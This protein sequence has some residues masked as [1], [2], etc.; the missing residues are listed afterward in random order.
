MRVTRFA[1]AVL[2]FAATAIL[3]GCGTQADPVPAPAQAATPGTPSAV[4]LQPATNARG[5]RAQPVAQS[6]PTGG[7]HQATG[8][9]VRPVAAPAPPTAPAV[10]HFA[11]PQGAMR[12]LA[13]AYNRID[14]VQLKHVTTPQ[15]R[16]ALLGMRPHAVNLQLLGC[17]ANSGR[18]DYDCTFSHDFPAAMHKPGKGGSAVFTVAP[19]DRVGWYMTVLESC[20]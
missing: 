18:G 1:P 11:T 13:S 15:G 20:D 17:K 8:G 16:A 12:Y 6:P 9:K 19:A 3:A 7:V 14:M 4:A 2:L 10:P 5:N